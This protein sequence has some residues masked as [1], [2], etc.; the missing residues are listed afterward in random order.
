MSV[1]ST[2]DTSK[3]NLIAALGTGATAAVVLWLFVMFS[4][5]SLDRYHVQALETRKQLLDYAR[6]NRDKIEVIL[7]R[8]ADVIINNTAAIQSLNDTMK[9]ISVHTR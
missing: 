2:G 1:G 9:R 4:R 7:N 3:V 5:D 6:E 8:Q